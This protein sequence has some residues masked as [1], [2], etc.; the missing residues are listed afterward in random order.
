[1][2]VREYTQALGVVLILTG[3]AGLMFGDRLLLGVLNVV[4]PKGIAHLLTGGLL[5]YIGF[6][7]TDEHLAR[8]AVAAIG[9]VYL[10]VGVLSFVLPALFGLHHGYSVVDNTVHLLVGILSLVISFGSGRNTTSRA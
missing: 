6:G 5:A 7:Q 3:A 8:I 10:F 4:I 2:P 9:V 1:M